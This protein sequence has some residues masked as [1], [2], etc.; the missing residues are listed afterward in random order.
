MAHIQHLALRKWHKIR[1]REAYN[2]LKKLNINYNKWNSLNP[3]EKLIEG[4]I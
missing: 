2:Y 3:D 1:F 4:C